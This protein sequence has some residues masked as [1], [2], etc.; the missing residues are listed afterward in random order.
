MAILT[1]SVAVFFREAT[2]LFFGFL[3]SLVVEYHLTIIEIRRTHLNV[4]FFDA[5][6]AD[7]PVLESGLFALD[8][9]F[10]R[11]I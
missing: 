4:S 1:S 10:I 6:L 3:T 8:R 7:L 9:R 2:A 11:V 5:A